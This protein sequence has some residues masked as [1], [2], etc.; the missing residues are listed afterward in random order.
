LVTFE[1][2]QRQEH[3][4]KCPGRD[5]PVVQ[6]DPAIFLRLSIRSSPHS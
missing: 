6:F 2:L 3:R 5:Q 1:S 4:A